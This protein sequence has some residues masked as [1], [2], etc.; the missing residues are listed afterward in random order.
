MKSSLTN[1]SSRPSSWLIHT[2]FQQVFRM[3]FAWP[4]LMLAVCFS[5][6]HAS[7]LNAE[8]YVEIEMATL[9]AAIAGAKLQLKLLENKDTD[10]GRSR[11]IAEDTYNSISRIY[12]DAGVSPGAALA[13]ENRNRRVIRTW[14]DSRPEVRDR[15][16]GL[17][18]ELTHL[19]DLI[20]TILAQE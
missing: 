12:R 5:N 15:L 20:E 4:V 10:I 13:W 9:E 11:K 14:L 2:D 18:E 16:D 17:N 3:V 19:S 8:R 6:A 1:I 7:E